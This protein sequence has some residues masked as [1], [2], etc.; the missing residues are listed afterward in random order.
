M[1]RSPDVAQVMGAAASLSDIDFSGQRGSRD[2]KSGG[3]WTV[4]DWEAP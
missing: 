3:N 1:G 2:G 4:V